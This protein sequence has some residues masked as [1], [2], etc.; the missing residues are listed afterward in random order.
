MRRFH[1]DDGEGRTRDQPVAAGKVARARDV[2]KRHFGNGAAAGGDELGEQLVMLRRIDAV[3]AAGEHR[4]RAACDARAMRRLV[5][6]ARQPRNDDEAGFAKIVRDRA[7]EFQPGGGGVARADNGNHRPHHGFKLAAH[8]EQGRRIVERRKPRR[9]AR[10]FG[11]KQGDAKLAAGVK[12]GL[13]FV[14]AADPPRPRCP[15]APREIGQPFQRSPCAAEM[16]QQRAEGPR[17]DILRADQPQAGDA[18]GV[19]QAFRVVD[20]I[21]AN[22]MEQPWRAGKG[23]ACH[24]HGWVG[25][26]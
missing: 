6:A 10:F 12:L 16:A 7:R 1:H 5:D 3:M 14:L 9:I 25:P 11:R 4:D 26:A 13:R 24:R 19:S 20:G 15:A 8:A 2:T 17:A 22:I 18:V 21:H 23:A